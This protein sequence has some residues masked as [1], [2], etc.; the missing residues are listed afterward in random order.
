MFVFLS[1]WLSILTDQ[2]QKSFHWSRGLL[3]GVN[4]PGFA[5]CQHSKQKASFEDQAEPVRHGRGR[6]ANCCS[7]LSVA[8]LAMGWHR[9]SVKIV[10]DDRTLRRVWSPSHRFWD[11]AMENSEMM[12][13]YLSGYCGKDLSAWDLALLHLLICPYSRFVWSLATISMPSSLLMIH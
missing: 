7:V 11:C 6:T 2:V 13:Q 5:K 9:L 3:L 1:S 4:I 10:Q 8:C 12:L